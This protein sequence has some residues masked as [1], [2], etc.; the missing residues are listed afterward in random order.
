MIPEALILKPKLFPEGFLVPVNT[1]ALNFLIFLSEKEL[2]EILAHLLP[3]LN[4]LQEKRKKLVDLYTDAK[5]NDSLFEEKKIEIECEVN[6]AMENLEIVKDDGNKWIERMEGL[7][8][9]Y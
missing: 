2:M 6:V 3:R 5:I 8:I 7:I 4:R 9:S 1:F